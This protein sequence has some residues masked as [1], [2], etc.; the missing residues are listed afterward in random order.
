MKLVDLQEKA[1]TD[2]H[3][4]IDQLMVESLRTPDI[5]CEWLK[6]RSIER[7]GLKKAQFDFAIIRKAKW[8]YYTGRAEDSVYQAKPFGHKVLKD[9]LDIYLNADA[10]L[11][12]AQAKLTI[13]EE[14]VEYIDRVL[15]QLSE[16][17][18][19]IRNANEALRFQN[20]N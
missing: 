2:L 15:K 3:I 4:R 16:R 17:Q 7:M 8:E 9:H 13:A 14:K 18:W 6:I 10:E 11:S 20:G 5:Y 12:E 19:H 1:K